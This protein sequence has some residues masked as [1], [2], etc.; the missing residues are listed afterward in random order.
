MNLRILTYPVL[1]LVL[2]APALLHADDSFEGW[3]NEQLKMKIIQLQKEVTLL[4]TKLQLAPAQTGAQGAAPASGVVATKDMLLDDF[5]GDR[6]KNG[7]AWA[8]LAD[9]ANLG[10]TLQPMPF[11][12]AQGGSPQSP[13]HSGRIH[14][15][16]GAGRAPWPWAMMSLNLPD[17]DLRAYRGISFYL[18]GKAGGVKVQLVKGSV[19]D[20][21]NFSAQVDTSAGWRKVTLLFSDFKQPAW[22]QQVSAVFDDVEQIAF[23]PATMDADFDFQ[24]DDLTLVK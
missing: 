8:S 22:A 2:V 12:A 4:R 3:T 24:I 5:E 1:A 19:K 15:H 16:L 9:A 23:Q 6:A 10:T 7:Q 20:F 21:A 11:E 18:K 13:G 17:G 14:G